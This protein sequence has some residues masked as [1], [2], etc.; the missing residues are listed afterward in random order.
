MSFKR[1]LLPIMILVRR[2]PVKTKTNLDLFGMWGDGETDHYEIREEICRKERCYEE[3][4]TKRKQ[5]CKKENG[6]PFCA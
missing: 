4:K 6:V 3:Q 1:S 2:E 5:W